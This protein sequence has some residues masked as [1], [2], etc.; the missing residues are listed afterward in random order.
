MPEPSSTFRD[1]GIIPDQLAP[2]PE[3][4]RAYFSGARVFGQYSMTVFVAALGLGLALLFALLMPWK[5]SLPGCP[6]A[7]AGFGV[8]VYLAVRND[9][10]TIELAGNSLRAKHLY[11]G[12]MRERSIADIES[13][14]TIV[15]Q[16]RRAETVITEK[17]LGRVRGIDIHFRGEALPLRVMRSDPA[18]TNAQQLIEAIVYRMQQTGEIDYEITDFAGKPLLRKIFWKG[19][20]EPPRPK[21]VVNVVPVCLMFMALMFGTILAFI[22]KG[23]AELRKLASVPPREIALG[24]LA[25]NGPGNNRHVIVINYR[26]GGFAC[27]TQNGV[28]TDVWVALFPAEPQAAG[29]KEIAVVLHSKQVRDETSLGRLLQTGRLAG[30]CSA[31]RQTGWGTS[32]GPKLVEANAG[33]QLTSAWEIEELSTPPEEAQVARVVAGAMACLAAV[34]GLAAFVFWRNLRIRPALPGPTA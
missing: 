10:G 5:L 9:Y 23:D 30:I 7:L 21:P 26:P 2:P 11:T 4:V 29:P 20:P 32:L 22:G 19:R 3:T 31:D 34:L 16:V 14:T 33:C 13:L 25:Q 17:L 28:W 24:A 8:L 12:H 6:A 27:Q 18:M 15:Y 1:F